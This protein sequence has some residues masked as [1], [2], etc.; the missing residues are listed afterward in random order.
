MNGLVAVVECN[1]GAWIAK[2]PRP[3]CFNAEHMGRHPVSGH[4]GGLTGASFEC[5]RGRCVCCPPPG[6]FQD[7]CGLRCAASWPPNV[8]DI[9]ALLALR[10]VVADRNWLPGQTVHDLLAENLERGVHGG[11]TELAIEGDR[12]TVGRASL[13]AA[14]RGIRQIEER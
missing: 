8:D 11:L 3:G 9:S 6:V 4:V 12:V 14:A 7:G 1:H 5:T 10:P 2:C 13:M